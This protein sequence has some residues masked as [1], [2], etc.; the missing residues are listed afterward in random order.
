MIGDD[1]SLERQSSRFDKLVRG[2]ERRRYW[3]GYKLVT[4]GGLSKRLLCCL[5]V[6]ILR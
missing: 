4:R 5:R 2:F 3:R 6:V 1:H